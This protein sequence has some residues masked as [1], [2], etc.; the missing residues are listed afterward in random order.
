M[1]TAVSD[2]FEPALYKFMFVSLSNTKISL[3]STF[4]KLNNFFFDKIK[5]VNCILENSDV[6][7]VGLGCCCCCMHAFDWRKAVGDCRYELHV[8][9]N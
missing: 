4:V 8:G 3:F 5:L 1:V 2:L 9:R 7:R 6:N